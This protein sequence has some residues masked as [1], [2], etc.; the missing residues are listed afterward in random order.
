MAN[1]LLQFARFDFLR[2]LCPS[3]RSVAN[4]VHITRRSLLDHPTQPP[5][6]EGLAIWAF[7]AGEDRCNFLRDQKVDRTHSCRVRLPGSFEARHANWH[8]EG[9]P[10][11]VP[12]VRVRHANGR[13]AS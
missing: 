8:P 11:Q 10:R 3:P 9:F 12:R 6:I 4:A 1:L 5:P 13:V 2:R 7:R